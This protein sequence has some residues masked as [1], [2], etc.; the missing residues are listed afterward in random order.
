MVL[1]LTDDACSY[2]RFII[3]VLNPEALIQITDGVERIELFDAFGHKV[4]TLTRDSDLKSLTLPQGVYMIRTTMTSGAAKT[5]KCV[6][7]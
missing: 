5:G 3:T 2:D 7:R 6:I 4:A 1:K